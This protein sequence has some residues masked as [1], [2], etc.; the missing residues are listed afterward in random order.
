[1]SFCTGRQ[2]DSYQTPAPKIG[3]KL[4]QQML[5]ILQEQLPLI[6]KTLLQQK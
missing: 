4:H 2:L 1:M 3:S 5:M 6:R